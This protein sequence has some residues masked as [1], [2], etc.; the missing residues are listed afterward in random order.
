MITL[1]P[2]ARHEFDRVS[3]IRV[4]PEQEPFC[5][6][7]ATHFAMDEPGCDFNIVARDGEPVGFFKI[8]RDYPSRYEFAR[9]GEIGLRGMMID[10]DQQGRGTG[11]A[12]MLALGPYLTRRYPKAGI[13]ILK[14]N[15]VNPAARAI[16][17]A[18]GFVDEGELYHGGNVS[19]QH[20]LRLNL[21]KFA[22]A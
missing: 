9:P 6:S 15:I 16:Y 12:A 4:A 7:I 18:G 11:K 13:C 2:L 8:D 5:G 17:L 14:V 21:R 19:A 20:I 1:E 10:R 22:V 3:H